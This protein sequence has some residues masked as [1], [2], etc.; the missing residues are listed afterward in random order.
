MEENESKQGKDLNQDMGKVDRIKEAIEIAILKNEST[1]LLEDGISKI[2]LDIYKIDK[3]DE[4]YEVMFDEDTSIARVKKTEKGLVFDYYNSEVK[5]RIPSSFNIDRARIVE[6]NRREEIL[7]KNIERGK[8]ANDLK[9]E[10]KDRQTALREELNQKLKSG[11]A[12]KME[13]DRE[14]STSENMRMFVKRAFGVDSQEIYRIQGDDPH[15][16][17]YVAET[18]DSEEPLKVLDLSTDNEGRNSLQKIWI[19]ENGEFKE[20]TVDSIL[21]RGNYAIA[22]DIPDSVGTGHTTTYLV[23]R[24]RDGK[25]L[26]IAAEEKNGSNRSLS[27]DSIEKDSMQR[28]NTVWEIEDIIESAQLAEKIGV[29]IK[30]KKLSTKEVDAVKKLKID[31]NMDDEEVI[32]AINAVSVLKE[33]GCNE[34]QIKKIIDR[35]REIPNKDRDEFI[36]QIKNKDK[37]ATQNAKTIYDGAEHTHEH[38][39]GPKNW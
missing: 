16:F 15:D 37:D 39:M 26:G 7:R 12:K 36:N 2:K 24:T 6:Q 18:G 34:D 21:M 1:V 23:S 25:Y 4:T 30:D 31:G 38:T 3:D 33:F 8:D 28:A 29:L 9:L 27:R 20:K 17:K 13:S 35:F 11:H 19:I 10:G 14:F 22:T 32:D 5:E